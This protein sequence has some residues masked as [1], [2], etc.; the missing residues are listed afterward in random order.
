[1]KNNFDIALENALEKEFCRLDNFENPFYNYGFTPQFEENM[2]KIIP[3]AE[4]TYISIGRKRIRKALVAAII[5]LLA[6]TITGCAITI[7]YLVEWNETQNDKQGTLD[8]TFE[9]DEKAASSPEE[10]A[11]PATPAGYAITNEYEDDFTYTIEYSDLQDNIIS[12]HRY[13]DVENMG[14]SIDNEDAAFEETTVN[15]CKGY[16]YSKEGINALYWADNMYFHVLMGTCD[17]DILLTM[18]K[19]MNY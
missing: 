3:K 19:D 17:M 6:I 4:F 16:T 1:M 14:V 15:G 8:V 11:C 5:A 13:N 12:Y 2:G 10:A 9:V 18:I 7:H